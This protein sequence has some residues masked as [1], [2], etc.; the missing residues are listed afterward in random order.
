MAPV[1]IA[2]KLGVS[3]TVA[4]RYVKKYADKISAETPRRARIIKNIRRAHEMKE[5]GM[6]VGDI[7]T[8]LGVSVKSASTYLNRPE[9]YEAWRDSPYGRDA[10]IAARIQDV[11]AMRKEGHPFDYIAREIGI[12]EASAR[13]YFYKPHDFS[14]W[15]KHIAQ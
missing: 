10:K 12:T 1:D 9:F 4:R 2:K 6:G 14:A 5:G 11:A 3:P 7:A 8:A 15:Q 13:N